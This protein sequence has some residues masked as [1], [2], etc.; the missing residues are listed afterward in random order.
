[1]GDRERGEGEGIAERNGGARTSAVRLKPDSVVSSFN[2][3]IICL[4]ELMFISYLSVAGS[5][6]LVGL[7][8]F[9][10]L[11]PLFAGGRLCPRRGPIVMLF[12]LMRLRARRS[13]SY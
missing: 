12:A 4:A 3:F 13:A 8:K 2:R 9:F 5:V 1:M 10:C 11:V 7:S 6:E